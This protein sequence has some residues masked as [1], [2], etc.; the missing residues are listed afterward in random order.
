[1]YQ[2]KF[3]QNISKIITEAF[4]TSTLSTA[5][6]KDTR[7]LN[8]GRAPMLNQQRLIYFFYFVL[9]VNALLNVPQKI[10]L[11]LFLV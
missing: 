11:A 3:L 6:L 5:L 7:I 2:Q 1:M 4:L 10:L 8:Y 9:A